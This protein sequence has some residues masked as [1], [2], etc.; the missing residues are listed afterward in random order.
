M[1]QMSAAVLPLEKVLGTDCWLLNKGHVEAAM[2]RI[3]GHST[4]R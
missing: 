4:L 1:P 2:T 3:G